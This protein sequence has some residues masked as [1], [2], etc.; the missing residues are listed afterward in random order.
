MYTYTIDPVLGNDANSGSPASP[1]RTH[2]ELVQRTFGSPQEGLGIGRPNNYLISTVIAPIKLI[3]V[4]IIGDL[5]ADDP[6]DLNVTLD[7]NTLLAY[8]G[9]PVTI[10]TGTLTTGTVQKN[11]ATNTPQ[12]LEDTVTPFTAADI[13]RRITITSGPNAGQF[14]WGASVAAGILRTSSFSTPTMTPFPDALIQQGLTTGPGAVSG[15][16][17]IVEEL[18]TVSLRAVQARSPASGPAVV[19]SFGFANLNF[20]NDGPTNLQLITLHVN[21]P[22]AVFKSCKWTGSMNSELSGI[23]RPVF[24]N[25]CTQGPQSL[26]IRSTALIRGGL[27]IGGTTVRGTGVSRFDD[28][29]MVQSGSFQAQSVGVSLGT[30][31]VFDSLSEGIGI[32]AAFT[33]SV[34]NTTQ[35]AGTHLLWGSGNV[36]AGVKLYG[37]SNALNYVSVVPSITGTAGDF[38]LAGATQ[39]RAWDEATSAYTPLLNN[40]WVNL[41]ATIAGGG[42]GGNAHNVERTA[43]IVLRG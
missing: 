35:F 9:T 25:C 13:G 12:Q 5:P 24:L 38:N 27:C 28:D 29:F 42:F 23:L 36:G 43:D 20:R 14:A 32:G 31:C 2:R 8:V 22:F 19:T 37:G 1:I 41:A 15:E 10:R 6:I 33:T 16:T 3:A 40:T 4:N 21:S 34:S 39:S 30:V 7:S 18:S 26:V 17:Y 11:R